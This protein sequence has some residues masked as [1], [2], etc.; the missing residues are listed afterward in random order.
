MDW[1][2]INIYFWI[3]I[4]NKYSKSYNRKWKFKSKKKYINKNFFSFPEPHRISWKI[5]YRKIKTGNKDGI[6]NSE[7]TILAQEMYNN[8]KNI[9]AITFIRVYQ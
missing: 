1:R 3:Y 7:I 9:L 5:I 4:N 8:L 6:S 2:N